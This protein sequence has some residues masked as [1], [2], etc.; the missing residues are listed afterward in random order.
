VQRDVDSQPG[1][2]AV[3]DGEGQGHERHGH[4]RRD[5]LFHVAP[6]DLPGDAHHHGAYQHQRRAHG[7]RGHAHQQRAEE[8]GR[9]E[10]GGHG[11]GRE[12]RPPALPDP[13]GGLDVGGHRGAPEPRAEHRRP[14]V[15][16]ER[17]VLALEPA[18]FLHEPSVLCHGVHCPRRVQ[19]VH[20]QE[21][22]Q[23]EPDVAVPE[24][25]EAELPRG[26]PDHVEVH[27]LPEV[28]EAG[29]A[30]RRVREHRHA[31][32]SDP[33]DHSDEQDAVDH[34]PLHVP[35]QARG[36]D[37]EADGAQ[38]ERRAAHGAAEAGAG[39]R[40]HVGAGGQRDQ[41]RR[42]GADEPDPLVRLE[43]REGQE[44]AD[45]D[46]RG[47]ADVP[48]DHPRQPGPESHG[49]QR[50]EHEA[51]QHHD[52][53][54]RAVADGPGSVEADHVVR[55]VGVGAH[56]GGQRQREVGEEPHGEGAGHRGHGRG[57]DQVALGARQ[58]LLV[59]RVSLSPDDCAV[60]GRRVGGGGHGG[61][62]PR[63]ART[64]A[65]GQDCGVHGDD[66][67]HGE[68]RGGAGAE[69]LGEGA[70]ARVQLE[71]PPHVAPGDGTVHGG[72]GPREPAPWPR[73]LGRRR[74][75]CIF[76]DVDF[77]VRTP[78]SRLVHVCRG[79]STSD[80]CVVV[81]SYEPGE[82]D[83]ELLLICMLV[84]EAAGDWTEG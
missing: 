24:A 80:A 71:V 35:A 12:P 50:E 4:E 79:S 18:A 23:G 15:H 27:H 8:E 45:A 5:A 20:V 74:R 65:V 7:P 37:Q 68:E 3:G 76:L 16:E 46:R 63:R 44:Q 17:A 11:D 78:P 49:G 48:R 14:G 26:A 64:A 34:A 42:A 58:A 39:G 53:Q 83:P 1:D 36:R 25:A 52:G 81:Y 73:C 60:R 13:R 33:G 62:V 30:R 57:H 21:R 54:R 43:P 56:A 2:D 77:V 84:G 61:A 40:V 31:G 28:V 19:D 67:G 82:R 66:V 41:R 6:L 29:I 69:L 70:L 38:P 32:A 72:L 59:P 9:Q 22:E 51:L 55:E 75:H 47:Q 10:A